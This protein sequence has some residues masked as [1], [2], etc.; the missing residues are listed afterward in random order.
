MISST[1]KKDGC[2][3]SG[4]MHVILSKI[5]ITKLEKDVVAPK[6]PLLYKRYVDGIFTKRKKNVPDDLL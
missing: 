6:T 2:T 1:S 4:P 5:Y 3:T